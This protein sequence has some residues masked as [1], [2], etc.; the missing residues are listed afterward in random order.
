[1]LFFDSKIIAAAGGVV[2]IKNRLTSIFSLLA[3]PAMVFLW[4]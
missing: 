4:A 2:V 3:L 1:M